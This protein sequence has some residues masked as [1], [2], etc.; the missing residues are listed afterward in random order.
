MKRLLILLLLPLLIIGCSKDDDVTTTTVKLEGTW[1]KYS[2]NDV[3]MDLGFYTDSTCVINY[4][5]SS[6]KSTINYICDYS[7]PNITLKPIYPILATFTGTIS[8][9]K[10]MIIKTD[11]K[12]FTFIR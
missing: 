11:S 3:T 10:K 2:D 7:Y 4:T 6:S 1:W 8:S 9:D 12:I 5:E